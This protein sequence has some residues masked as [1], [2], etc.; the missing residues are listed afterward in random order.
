MKWKI[1]VVVVVLLILAQIIFGGKKA[2][3]TLPEPLAEPVSVAVEEES[4]A[5]TEPA[6]RIEPAEQAEQAETA[7]PAELPEQASPA[8]PSPDDVTAIAVGDDGELRLVRGEDGWTVA[9]R[10][11]FPADGERI[12]RLLARAAEAGERHVLLTNL[13]RPEKGTRLD[14]GIAEQAAGLFARAAGAL[15]RAEKCGLVYATGGATA[16]AA[17]GE[18]GFGSITLRRELMPGVVLSE[19]FAEGCP[20]RWFVSKAGGFGRPDTLTRLADFCSYDTGAT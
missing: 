10:D 18:L 3:E 13:T 2:E 11:S 16:V 8:L 6:E 17:A 20:A 19:C 1:L 4:P 12:A 15:C 9:N 7:E 14:A 5:Q